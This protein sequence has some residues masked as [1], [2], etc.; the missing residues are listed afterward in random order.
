MAAI[1]S[2]GGLRGNRQAPAYNASKAYQINYMEALRQKAAR[3][4]QPVFVTDIRPGLV[5]TEMAKGEGL[6]WVSPV[7]KAARQIVFAIK[8]KKKIAYVTKRWWFIAIIMKRIPRIIY[9]RM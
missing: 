6:F 8:R 2:V 4:K 9:D 7:D 1:S 3:L 5:D